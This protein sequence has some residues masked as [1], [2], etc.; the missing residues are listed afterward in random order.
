[1]FARMTSGDLSPNFRMALM[2]KDMEYAIKEGERHGVSLT[3]A[4][5]PLSAFSRAMAAGHGD[6]DFAAV[7]EPIRRHEGQPANTSR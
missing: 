6:K 4:A 3:T 2:A 5:L 1:M 7:V